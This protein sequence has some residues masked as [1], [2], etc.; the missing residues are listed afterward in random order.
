MLS[1]RAS[2]TVSLIGA[3]P[4]G[5]RP[6]ARHRRSAARGRCGRSRRTVAG[7]AG[8][9]SSRT[10]GRPGSGG[11]PGRPAGA[12]RADGVADPRER[13]RQ[14]GG[15]RVQRVGED[16]VGGAVL[17]HAAGVHH[18]DP[19]AE[20]GQHGQV[21]ADHQQPD[22]EVADQALE[23]VQHLRLHHHVERGGR[24]VGHDQPRVAGQRHRDHDAL[25]LAAGQ[26]VR[27]GPRPGRRQ[28][29]LLEQL[30]DA[31]VDVAVG[32]PR[33]VQPD[34]LRDLR[35][36]PLHGVERVQRALEDHRGAGPPHARAGRPTSWSARPRPRTAPARSRGRDGGWRRRIV[37]A[38]VD[39]PQ[40][41]SPATPTTSPA[42][43][44]R[45]TPRTAGTSPPAVR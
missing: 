43:T 18:R 25:P 20:V 32:Q 27:V 40:P 37:A 5:R 15:V 12:Y 42:P 35:P 2:S 10:A 29:D 30:A 39:L 19:V 23:H 14:R 38:S 7:S 16:L 31:A 6:T 34:R 13:R 21:V 3:P 26:L 1:P 8:G 41:D 11:S 28:A 45:E 9:T 36:D 17:D 44:D 24:L 33:L 4:G 22:V